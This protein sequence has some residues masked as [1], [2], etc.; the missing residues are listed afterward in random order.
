MN[1]R[2]LNSVGKQNYKMYM[3]ITDEKEINQI[4]N[5]NNSVF[6][7]YKYRH[8]LLNKQILDN[9]KITVS[10]LKESLE[11]IFLD[12][13]S[14]GSFRIVKDMLVNHIDGWNMNRLLKIHKKHK[15]NRIFSLLT[16]KYEN[17]LII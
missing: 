7:M 8:G 1:Q 16:I 3:L 13:L 9:I 10:N 15:Y 6:E 14:E 11:K 4:L 12:Y 5:S 17:W 2:I